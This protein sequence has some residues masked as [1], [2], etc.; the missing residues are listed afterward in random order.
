MTL[1]SHSQRHLCLQLHEK[2]LEAECEEKEKVC[3]DC[4]NW[5]AIEY[6]WEC[7]ENRVNL[8]SISW[9]AVPK[10]HRSYV[11]ILNIPVTVTWVQYTSSSI[12]YKKS[13]SLCSFFT[14]WLTL[15]SIKHKSEQ[16]HMFYILSNHLAHFKK[17]EIRGID[18]DF[19][20]KNHSTSLERN[21][22]AKCIYCPLNLLN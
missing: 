8:I 9:T 17:R 15:N 1:S 22:K 19:F 7:K 11:Y 21:R 14:H 18:E 16:G 3:V 2:Q 10:K 20:E 13:N 5:K 6:P 12:I 4:R